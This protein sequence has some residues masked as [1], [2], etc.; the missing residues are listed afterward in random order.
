[1]FICLSIGFFIMFVTGY[2]GVL[3]IPDWRN[4]TKEAGWVNATLFNLVRISGGNFFAD[5][6]TGGFVLAM[7]ITNLVSTTAASRLL[8]GMGRD[9][10]ISRRLF[11]TVSKSSKTPYLNIILIMLVE[12]L[13][14]TYMNQD[15]IAELISYGAIAGFIILNVS[16]IELGHQLSMKKMISKSTICYEGSNF[17]FIF[18]F[19]VLPA[20]GFLIMLL[21][22]LNMQL[23]T[24]LSGT[25]WLIIGII[26]YL[27]NTKI[28]L[29][30]FSEIIEPKF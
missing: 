8:F 23:T 15:Q 11:A 16:L 29:H 9:G 12:L 3:A 27:I 21:I 1:M 18:K 5:I 14:G 20:I 4:L 10:R 28:L 13:L 6:Y 7:A 25:L 30:N 24:L 19:F 26:Y 22:F 2:L 17:L